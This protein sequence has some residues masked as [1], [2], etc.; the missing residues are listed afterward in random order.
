MSLQNLFSARTSNGPSFEKESSRLLTAA[1]VNRRF[2]QMLLSDPGRA[3]ASGYGGEAFHLGSDEK[4]S[5]SSIRASSL[6]DFARQ[7]NQMKDVP[8]FYAYA[9]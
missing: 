8:A 9:D 6:E 5:I 1:V 7:L 2:R 3:L 4:E